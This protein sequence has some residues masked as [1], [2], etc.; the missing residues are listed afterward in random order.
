MRYFA[1][2]LMSL[3]GIASVGIAQAHAD[4]PWFFAQITCAPELGYFSIR[5]ILIMNLPHGGPYLGNGFMEP[6]PQKVVRALEEKN[7]IYDSQ[8]LSARPFTCTSPHFAAVPAPAFGTR[9]E[10]D[11]RSR[12]LGTMRSRTITK[13]SYCRMV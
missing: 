13:S 5:K 1:L 8:G 3:V 7:R 2:T 12:S 4:E 6:P 9:A 10:R 11:L